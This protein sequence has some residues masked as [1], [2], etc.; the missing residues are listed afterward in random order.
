MTYVPFPSQKKPLSKK[1][2]KWRED[3]IDGAA[4][5]AI[6][7]DEGL[8]KAYR[9]KKINYNLYADILDEDDVKKIVD[10]L[11]LDSEYTPAKMQNY[12]IINPKVD[13]LWGEETKKKFE[14][15]L[16]TIND[17]AVSE[18][19]EELNK[20]LTQILVEQIQA[21]SVSEED[22]KEK[23]SKFDKYKKY[24]Y[25]DKRELMGTWIMK[26]LWEEQDIKMKLDKGFKDAL[27]VAEEIYQWDVIGGQPILLK[28]NPLNVHTLRS[29]ESPY[30]EDA[31]I[32]V[33]DSYFPPGK[34]ID[35]YNEYLTDKE[36][37]QIEERSLNSSGGGGSDTPDMTT[38]RRDIL[39]STV[40]S[41]VFESG[42]TEYSSP[43]DTNGNI[44]VMK[45]Y[46]KSMRKMVQ[47][48]YYDSQGDE[49]YELMPEQY[50]IDKDAG[51]EGKTLWISEW[52]EGHKIACGHSN[53]DGI[54][55]KMQPRPI[56]F[57]RAENPSLCSPGIVG[58]I[59]NTNDNVAI[60]LFDRMKPYQYMY[61]ALMY[62]VEL[63]ISTN[64]GKIM[65]LDVT[66]VPDGWEVDKWISYAK[67]LK[68]APIDPFKEGKKGAAIGKLSGNM[69]S[70][71]SNPVIDMTQGNTIQLYISMMDHIKQEVGEIV[72]ISKA[73]EGNISASS[74]SGNV[75]REVIQSSHQTEYWFA[76]HAHL[77]K[78]V[79]ATGLETAK[80]AW[81]KSGTKK[82]Q[83]VSD[84]MMTQMINVDVE[85]LKGIDMDLHVSNSREDEELMD[86]MKQLAHAGIQNDKINF[87]TLMDIYTSDAVSSVRRKIETSE[88]EKA[89]R[90]QDSQ[91][92]AERMQQAQLEADAKEVELARAH[93]IAIEDKKLDNA[94]TLE[95][96]KAQLKGLER[97]IDLDHDG[98]SDEVEIHKTMLQ[99]ESNSSES[100]KQRNHESK[101]AEKDRDNKKELERLKGK[102][103]SSA[104]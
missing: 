66:Q 71:N 94:V 25:Q 31:E 93:E 91:E 59:Y 50:K 55:V 72:G 80:L 33:I 88:E 89:K 62:N 43:Y 28:H 99:N 57:R 58:T 42:I 37:E 75:Q 29:G 51:E 10:P 61:N 32:I 81:A 97:G 39:E 78:R 20:Q 92:Q 90:D 23:L 103:K 53:D 17:D 104:K 14:W 96:L 54:Y 18:K 7:R 48:K 13:V 64:W 63:C 82:L 44:R 34:I 47:V 4:G 6:F 26:H 22:L 46:W 24:T 2:D 100:E 12:P 98:V 87:S 102:N 45:V 83:F 65:K 77:K 76:E 101:E 74:T 41:A 1:N 85:D 60:S 52:W 15:R 67:I 49:T 19:E 30:V 9:T 27:L 38:D 68:I 21:E 35:E 36:I 86:T 79:L 95:T 70:S 69:Q 40:D 16:R 3:C 8:R 84:D 11:G 5:M 56:Q 73:R